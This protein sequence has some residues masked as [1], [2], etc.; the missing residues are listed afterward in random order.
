MCPYGLALHHPA[1]DTLL[2]YA[3]QGCPVLTGKPW[4]V[5]EMQAAIDR[6]PHASALQLDA[7]TQLHE[8]VAAKVQAGQAHIV[9]WK[10]IQRDPP[11]QLKISPISMVPHKSQKF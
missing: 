10:D 9:D 7:I 6:G 8:E 4:S 5:K 3:T 11:P 1:A 2:Q